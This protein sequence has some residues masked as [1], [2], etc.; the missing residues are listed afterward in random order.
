MIGRYKIK[1]GEPLP[2]YRF[3]P[4]ECI[5]NSNHAREFSQGKCSQKQFD[6]LKMLVVEVGVDQ[7]TGH[8]SYRLLY[9]SPV[10]VGE[11]LPGTGMDQWF[12]K[13][14]VDSNFELCDYPEV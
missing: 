14:F 4:G 6:A 2:G 13:A 7:K 12:L 5:V 9:D 3:K 8:E 1:I 10:K 11:N